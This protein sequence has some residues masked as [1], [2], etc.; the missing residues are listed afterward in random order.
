M[1]QGKAIICFFSNGLFQG[2]CLST[3]DSSSP[4]CIAGNF[5]PEY[6]DPNHHECMEAD[7]FCNVL[8]HHNNGVH[9]D[10]KLLIR[11]PKGNDAGG[12]STHEHEKKVNKKY[13]LT[14]ETEQ[15]F[16]GAEACNLKNKYFN[17]SSSAAI[18]DSE[19]VCIGEMIFGKQQ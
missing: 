4:Y 19:F 8:I 18:G 9:Q 11:R 6:V 15:F 2:H 14:F 3:V 1:F 5:L 7:D 13:F 16:S 12:M 10:I 17:T